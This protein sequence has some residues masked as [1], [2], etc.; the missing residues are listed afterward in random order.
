[1]LVHYFVH[2]TGTDYGMSGIPRVVKN[3]ARQLVLRPEVELVPVCWSRKRGTL[4]H[5]EQKLLDNLARHGGPELQAT[6]PPHT[7]VEPQA[8]SW[9]L[10]PEVPHLAS[11]DPDYPS[12]LIDEPI[13]WARDHGAP[14]AVIVHDIMPLTY[15]L[16]QTRGRA[17]ADMAGAG[18]ADD[19]QNQKLRFTVYAHALALAD[20]L[21]P[22]SLTSRNLLTEWLVRHGHQPLLLPPMRPIH[23]PEEVLGAPRAVP[24]RN[25]RS[26]G[27][28]KEF[29]TVG[30]VS[31]HKNQLAAMAAF[32]KLIARRPDLD[33]RL[34]VVG[35]VAADSALAASL[36]AKRSNGRI[37]LHGF[38][39]DDQVEAMAKRAHASV[40][41]SLAE[42]FGVP[43]AE[44]LWRGKPCLCSNEG[45]IAEI[46]AGGGC[47]TVDPHSLSEIE[48]GFETLATNSRR[49]E[50]LL[51]EIA[52]RRMRTWK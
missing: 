2:V 40:F 16:G 23:L 52:S 29:V 9:L 21:L 18:K 49:Y 4:V 22:V 3:L 43:V 20:L 34:N 37:V 8:E 11:H 25:S 38:L 30:T 41:V 19:G 48:A 42:G 28:T 33:I 45:S 50:A 36:L 7:P 24:H 32:L 31:A 35:S 39:P 27:G 46:A 51:Q 6:R 44:S 47:L 17:F 12:L 15:Q 13:G 1:M 14:I 26:A 5:A 10:I